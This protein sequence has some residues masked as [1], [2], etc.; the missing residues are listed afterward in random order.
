M[1]APTADP[2]DVILGYYL[3]A[4]EAGQ[5][6]EP[7]RAELRARFPDQAAALEEFFRDQ[8]A[9]G[10]TLPPRPVEQPAS[11]PSAETWSFPGGP[12]P[13]DTDVLAE[14]ADA[15]GAQRGERLA[16]ERV[17]RGS[18]DLVGIGVEQWVIDDLI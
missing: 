7:L 1:S 16:M 13:V 5:P 11:D 15:E 10:E 6:R 2:L 17:E 4:V 12:R 8:D 3:M 18:A 14:F 9:M